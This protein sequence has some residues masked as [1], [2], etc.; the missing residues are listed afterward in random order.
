MSAKV[1]WLDFLAYQGSGDN[2]NAEKKK[3]RY[4]IS[5]LEPFLNY[6]Y[7]VS[8]KH[9]REGQSPKNMDCNGQRPFQMAWSPCLH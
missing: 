7:S 9:N 1:G 8:Q 2:D 4:G 6:L 5:I 3:K